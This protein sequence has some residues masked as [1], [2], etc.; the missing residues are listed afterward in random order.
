MFIMKEIVDVFYKNLSKAS[1]VEIRYI[2]MTSLQFLLDILER[3]EG[4]DEQIWFEN[5]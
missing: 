5:Q 4:N 1:S 3:K 2:P